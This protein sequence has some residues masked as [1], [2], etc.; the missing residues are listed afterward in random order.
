VVNKVIALFTKKQTFLP[1]EEFIIFKDETGQI[2]SAMVDEERRQA[3]NQVLKRRSGHKSSKRACF[4]KIK[5]GRP[6]F[7]IYK[8]ELKPLLYEVFRDT[9]NIAQALV[10]E[11]IAFY[12]S[13]DRDFLTMNRQC[14]Q[15]LEHTQQELMELLELL[16]GFELSVLS[17]PTQVF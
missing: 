4:G 17:L 11:Y 8:T 10:K 13:L 1:P 2:V 12:K 14:A 5:N 15:G 9:E 7:P 16:G 3:A 6:F